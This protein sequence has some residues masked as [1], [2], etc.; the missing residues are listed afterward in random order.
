[1]KSGLYESYSFLIICTF[2]VNTNA[3]STSLSCKVYSPFAAD[4]RGSF[5]HHLKLIDVE[6]TSKCVSYID[7]IS[8]SLSTSV[9]FVQRLPMP[10]NAIW[11]VF[12]SRNKTFR[13]QIFF[14][15][16]GS[17]DGGVSN[18]TPSTKKRNE[19]FVINYLVSITA[20]TA[21]ETSKLKSI[22]LSKKAC[23]PLS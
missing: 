5:E 14:S 16:M 10:A 19:S 17:G 9:S 23:E 21:S 6:M 4:M 8:L 2:V 22:L 13:S 1:M 15:V 3:S 12:I 11:C 18:I 20:A 7:M